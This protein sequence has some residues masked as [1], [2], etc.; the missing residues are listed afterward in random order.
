M[1]CTWPSE[2]S[3]SMMLDS[4]LSRPHDDRRMLEQVATRLAVVLEGRMEP[5]STGLIQE[6]MRTWQP[7]YGAHLTDEDA[8]RDCSST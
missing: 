6:T 4:C 3:V 7:Y 5:A 2:V 1:E 8:R